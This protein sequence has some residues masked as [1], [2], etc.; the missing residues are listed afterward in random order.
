MNFVDQRG[1]RRSVAVYAVV[2]LEAATAGLKQIRETKII[3]EG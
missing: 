3:G 1:V 2:S